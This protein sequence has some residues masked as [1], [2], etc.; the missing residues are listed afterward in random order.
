[1]NAARNTNQP[2]SLYDGSAETGQGQRREEIHSCFIGCKVD[3]KP[4]E[5]AQEQH[6]I[7]K[8]LPSMV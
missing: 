4:S 6:V 3:P 7:F 2:Q 1:M 5:V 8:L